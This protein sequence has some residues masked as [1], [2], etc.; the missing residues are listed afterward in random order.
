MTSIRAIRR[1]KLHIPSQIWNPRGNGCGRGQLF[2]SVG[3]RGPGRSGGLGSGGSGSAGCRASV[4]VVERHI[5]NIVWVVVRIKHRRTMLHR[6][7]WNCLLNDVCAHYNIFHHTASCV[8]SIGILVAFTGA[9][10]IQNKLERHQPHA[11]EC[12][13]VAM[14]NEGATLPVCLPSHN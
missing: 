10:V 11:T 12:A 9:D 7:E 5:R 8:V 13:D 6:S 4:L 3:G 14:V 1:I 2:R